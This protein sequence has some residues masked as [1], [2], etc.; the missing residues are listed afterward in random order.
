MIWCDL[1]FQWE[2]WL[3]DKL[4][5]TLYGGASEE[6]MSMMYWQVIG[7]YLDGWKWAEGIP[8]ASLTG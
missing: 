4:V 2:I 5:A 7:L 1:H 8:H 6:E 3:H